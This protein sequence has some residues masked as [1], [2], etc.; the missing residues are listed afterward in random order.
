MAYDVYSALGNEIRV[1][2]LLCLSKRAKNV[3]EMI[4]T[5]GLAQSAVSQ[6]LAKLKKARLVVTKKRGKLMQY[7][8]KDR[9]IAAVCRLMQH[10]QQ[11]VQ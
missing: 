2:L 11:E 8:L 6:H 9:K 3:T 10:L 4:A 1:K 5:C 7:S